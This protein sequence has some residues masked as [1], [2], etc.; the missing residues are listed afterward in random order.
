MLSQT[1]IMV[2]VGLMV[3]A[4]LSGFSFSGNEKGLV[5]DQYLSLIHI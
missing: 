1:R 4:D 3:M 5:V 2:L